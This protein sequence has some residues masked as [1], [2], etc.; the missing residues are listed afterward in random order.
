MS[1]P[2]NVIQVLNLEA[3][4]EVFVAVELTN[5]IIEVI[6]FKKLSHSEIAVKLYVIKVE[7]ERTFN[8][9]SLKV[10]DRIQG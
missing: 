5:V 2:D 10:S 6:F 4:H 1:C 9:F 7:R 8:I 3:R